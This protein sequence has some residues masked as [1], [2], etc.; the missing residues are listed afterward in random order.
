MLFRLESTCECAGNP[1][2]TRVIEASVPVHL[3]SQTSELDLGLVA[4]ISC[5][6]GARSDL[7]VPAVIPRQRQFT[8]GDS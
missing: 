4:V 8:P 2:S 6:G 7:S 1:K 5:Q 3:G